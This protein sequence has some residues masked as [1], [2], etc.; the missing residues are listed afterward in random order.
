MISFLLSAI[1]EASLRRDTSNGQG[2]WEVFN[3][4]YIS[5]GITGS[6][7][8][9]VFASSLAILSTILQVSHHQRSLNTDTNHWER[10]QATLHLGQD[11]RSEY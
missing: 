2:I 10:S 7:I 4:K 5:Y 1:F 8:A 9:F 3:K 6:E 11:I